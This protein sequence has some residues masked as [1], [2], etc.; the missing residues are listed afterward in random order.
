M[1]SSALHAVIGKALGA[2]KLD[3]IS[4]ANITHKSEMVIVIAAQELGF[5]VN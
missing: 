3:P 5:K 2:D 4:F 1:H